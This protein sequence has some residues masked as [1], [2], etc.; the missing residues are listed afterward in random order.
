VVN[1]KK[2]PSDVSVEA[3]GLQSEVSKPE[4]NCFANATVKILSLLLPA[5]SLLQGR[6]CNASL[7]M[8]LIST[9]KQNI[10]VLRSE[11]VFGEIADAA[12]FPADAELPVVPTAER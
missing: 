9:A 7:A 2:A 4:F 1:A 5:N 11:E 10:L 12:G 6:S 8:E 3:A